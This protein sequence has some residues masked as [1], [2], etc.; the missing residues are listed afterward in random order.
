MSKAMEKSKEVIVKNGK[1]VGVILSIDAYEEILERLEDF[2]DLKM[3]RE[4]GRKPVEFRQFDDFF[5][6]NK[7]V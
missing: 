3:L 5:R 4:M 6:E 7:S 1:P 2:E